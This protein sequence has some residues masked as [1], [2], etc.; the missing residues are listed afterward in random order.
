MASFQAKIGWN[1]LRKRENKNYIS[2]TF[3][4]DVLEKIP[5]NSK[6]IKKYQY[7]II[8]SQ[9]RIEKAEKERKSKLSF[10]YV[11]NRWVREN[12]KK[13]AKKLKNTIMASFLAKIGW[14]RLRMGE[15]KNYRAVSF[16]HDAKSKITKKVEKNLKN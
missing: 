16:L 7:G 2:I 3:L 4:P 11:P 10:G 12:S 8:S 14:K 5:K 13:V 6:K 1:R 15:N 9:N